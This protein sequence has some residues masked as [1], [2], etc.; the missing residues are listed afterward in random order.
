MTS[1]GADPRAVPPGR[2]RIRLDLGYDG[3]GLSGW[4]RQPERD[5]V[6][7]RVETA[8]AEVC[9]EPITVHCAGRTDAGVHARGQ[10]AHA[11]IPEHALARRT[12]HGLAAQLNRLMGPQVFCRAVTAAPADFDARFAALSRHYSYR[13]CDDPQQRDPLTRNFVVFHPRALAESSM[14]TAAAALVGEHDFAAFCRAK[15]GA[16]TIRRVLY[17]TVARDAA[18][19]LV[20]NIGADAFCHSMVRSV[21]GALV[22]VGEGRREPEWV[23]EVLHARRRDSAAGVMAAAGLVLDRVDYP[24][25]AEMAARIREARQLRTA[26]P[27]V[28]QQP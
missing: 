28:G 2:T 6:Q 1:P 16:T 14:A 21:V 11:D 24:P 26:E 15:A 9:G 19:L 17:V 4:A 10:V 12:W 5:T 25:P 23:A 20:I 13:I 22:A 7:Q 3:T 18:G 8:L 27:T